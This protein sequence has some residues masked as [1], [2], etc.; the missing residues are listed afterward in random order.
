L[1]RFMRPQPMLVTFCF[2]FAGVFLC[3]MGVTRA[4][5]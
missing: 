5:Q 2:P 1:A 4:S 3:V